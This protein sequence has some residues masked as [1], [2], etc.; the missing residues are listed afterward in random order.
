[1]WASCLSL[2]W[3][4]AE[5]EYDAIQAE[6]VRVIGHEG[7]EIPA[8]VARPLG[9]GP[10]S[11]MVVLHHAPGWDEGTKEKVRTFATH[12]YIA[13]APHLHYRDGGPD[14]SPDDAAAATRAAGGVPDVRCLGDV[15]GSIRYI[16]SIQGW[17]RKIG[18][19][20][21][22]AGGRQTYIVAANLK[23]G[24]AV[25]CY[26]G[27][28]VRKPE[29]LSLNSPIAP[30]DMTEDI[31]CPVL[32]LSGS[33]DK[34]PSPQEAIEV[35]ETLKKYGKQSEFVI[36]DD[37]GHSFFDVDKSAYRQPAATDGWSRI[38]KFLAANLPA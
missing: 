19:I 5:M 23:I 10:Y 29:R 35:E 25:V 17:N 9:P 14:S 3:G 24:A 38:W 37:A 12:G 20:G 8:Y 11:A 27:G 30:I 21:Y 7:D 6:T 1:M 15:E 31:S 4:S 18:S 32:W 33:E 36:Y 28:I 22:C 13:L 2:L 16:T 26:G 34:N